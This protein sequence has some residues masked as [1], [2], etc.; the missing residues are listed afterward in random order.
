M[1]SW[2]SPIR[3]FHPWQKC[4]AS[5]PVLVIEEAVAQTKTH[6]RRRAIYY[7]S[8]SRFAGLRLPWE[9]AEEIPEL[10]PRQQQAPSPSLKSN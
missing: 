10:G 7:W 1:H 2:T 9:D 6:V 4:L 5:R 3:P 8:F